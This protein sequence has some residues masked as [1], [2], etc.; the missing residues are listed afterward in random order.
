MKQSVMNFIKNTLLTTGLTI[1]LLACVALLSGGTCIFVK[2]IFQVLL[3][4]AC[5][6]LALR[7]AGK[8]ESKYFL[9]EALL[10]ITVIAVVTFLFALLFGWF[11]STPAWVL[12][13]MVIIIYIIGSAFQTIRVTE[14][15][16]SINEIL[17]KRKKNKQ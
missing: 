5:F 11:S 9:L 10:D 13:L 7:V 17:E 16:H 12:I 15:I 1:A 6:H 4:N 14:D 8:F 2:T 3:A